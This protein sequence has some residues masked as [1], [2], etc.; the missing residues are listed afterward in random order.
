M[1]RLFLAFAGCAVLSGGGALAGPAMPVPM[2]PIIFLPVLPDEAHAF[3]YIAQQLH[4]G[5]DSQ[6]LQGLQAASAI[7]HLHDYRGEVILAVKP[8]ILDA[9]GG[10]RTRAADGNYPFYVFRQTERGWQLLGEMR[11]VGYAWSTQTRHLVFRMTTAQNGTP[12][13]AA[14]VRYEVNPSGLVNLTRLAREEAEPQPPFKP[15]WGRAF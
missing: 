4:L 5:E 12:G 8:E 7:D 6:T 11:G 14:L 15:D 10:S 3:S 9:D 1:S 13:G 2:A